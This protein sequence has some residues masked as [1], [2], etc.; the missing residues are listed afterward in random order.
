MTAA[1]ADGAGA[2]AGRTAADA[3]AAEAD[4]ARLRAAAGRRA[5]R[6]AEAAADAALPPLIV[7]EAPSAGAGGGGGG[8][9]AAVTAA[10]LPRHVCWAVAARLSVDDL[11]A[12]ARACRFF[13][14]VYSSAL[15]LRVFECLGGVRVE[16]GWGRAAKDETRAEAAKRAT[17]AVGGSVAPAAAAPTVPAGLV[18]VKVEADPTAVKVEAGASPVPALGGPRRRA[19]PPSPRRVARRAHPLPSR[20][21]PPRPRAPRDARVEIAHHARWSRR[22]RT[23]KAWF[24]LQKPPTSMATQVRARMASASGMLGM[25]LYCGD[26]RR[27]FAPTTPGGRVVDAH[28]RRGLDFYGHIL[29][30]PPKYSHEWPVHAAW[31]GC[32]SVGGTPAVGL[33]PPRPVVASWTHTI[34]VVWTSRA[35]YFNGH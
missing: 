3:A 27:R 13:G 12:A 7:V 1:P 16:R 32:R 10:H 23:P 14:A 28:R 6:A 9:P 34:G 31:L 2:L 33:H 25:N 22:G 21:V 17:G 20:R 19:P 11:A 35:F 30:W 29:L 8:S 26:P 18:M 24:G 4:A 5:Y 15:S